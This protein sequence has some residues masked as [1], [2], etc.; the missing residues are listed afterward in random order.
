LVGLSQTLTH[1]LFGTAQKSV[2]YTTDVVLRRSG[3]GKVGVAFLITKIKEAQSRIARD[4]P[5]R[6]TRDFTRTRSCHENPP[7]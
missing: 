1:F 5:V 2:H 4:G 7:V 3:Y 6:R